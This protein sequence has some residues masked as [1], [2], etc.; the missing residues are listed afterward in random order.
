MKLS[1]RAS[2]SKKVRILPNKEREQAV[3]ESDYQTDWKQVFF[4]AHI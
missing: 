3:P 2:K 4:I 1:Y